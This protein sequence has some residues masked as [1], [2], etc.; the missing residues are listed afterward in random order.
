ML[1]ANY[2]TI[3][4]IAINHIIVLTSNKIN[5]LSFPAAQYFVHLTNLQAMFPWSSPAKTP[6][7]PQGTTC[8]LGYSQALTDHHFV[9]AARFQNAKKQGPGNRTVAVTRTFRHSWL[10]DF[11]LPSG[12]PV[13]SL[14]ALHRTGKLLAPGRNSHL[15]MRTFFG[16]EYVFTPRISEA[17]LTRLI[18]GYSAFTDL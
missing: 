3:S 9:M 12:G 7:S 16:P 11:V 1:D 14:C 17:F 10:S 13:S 5:C 15:G 8:L 2:I 18:V 4:P 6:L